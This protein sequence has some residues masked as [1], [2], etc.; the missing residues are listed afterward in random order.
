MDLILLNHTKEPVL[1]LTKIMARRRKKNPR[2]GTTFST[3]V[4][5]RFI[6]DLSS[7]C[8]ELL[9]D[10]SLIFRGSDVIDNRFHIQVK[11]GVVH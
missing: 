8:C 10:R 9:A 2:N 3:C 11:V 5:I 6:V 1:H 4:V 7:I